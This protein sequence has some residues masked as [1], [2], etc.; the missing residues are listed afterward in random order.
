[1]PNT[2]DDLS[3]AY[4]QAVKS[5]GGKAALKI[6]TDATGVDSIDDVLADKIA[7]AIVALGATNAPT[8]KAPLKTL[9]GLHA[10]MNNLSHDIFEKRNE[11]R[12][13]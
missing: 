4:R 11:Q 3:S 8:A 13:T 2:R 1:M 10:H 6:L 12:S 5:H 7:G 9:A